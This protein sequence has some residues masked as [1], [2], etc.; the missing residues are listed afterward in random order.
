MPLTN[1]TAAQAEAKLALRQ[2]IDKELTALAG[3]ESAPNTIPYFTGSGA[4]DV[5]ALT[6][7]C[8]TLLGIGTPAGVR[9]HLEITP[10]NEMPVSDAQST[11]ISD[12][13]SEYE[14]GLI[15]KISN[16]EEPIS[17]LA[18]YIEAIVLAKL[19]TAVA[20]RSVPVGLTGSWLADT[21]IPSG[22]LL[23]YGQAVSRTVYSALFG[24]F[25]TK[26]GAGDGST[27]FNLPNLRGRMIVHRDNMGGTAAGLVT[28]ASGNGAA[29]VGKIGGSQML[30]EHNHGI[31][32][33]SQDVPV[34][35]YIGTRLYQMSIGVRKNLDYVTG[36]NASGT[37]NS[38]NMP[39]Y[40]TADGIVYAGV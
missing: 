29:S 2:P 25:G 33:Y 36:T 7:F 26:Y 13:I 35:I 24:V 5:T 11:A 4:A 3:V 20:L 14:Q 10:D 30:Q 28:T 8:K 21:A 37:G 9:A 15:L 39:P 12:A 17:G 19:E 23:A 32:D 6:A 27:T 31:N 34:W 16:G 38:Q 18:A 40:I 22:W 1:I